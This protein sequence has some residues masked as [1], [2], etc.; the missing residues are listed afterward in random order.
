MEF[1]GGGGLGGWLWDR[2]WCGGTYGVPLRRSMFGV[3]AREFS[4]D[5][6]WK[7]CP[8]TEK[9]KTALMKLGACF[10]CKKQGHAAFVSGLPGQK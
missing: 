4:G 7:L 9:E 6:G 2:L 1:Q 10:R 8:L 3:C 5:D